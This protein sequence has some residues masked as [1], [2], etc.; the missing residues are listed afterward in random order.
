MVESRSLNVPLTSQ[1]FLFLQ[2]V[3]VPLCT[4][5]SHCT[6]RCSDGSTFSSERELRLRRQW[7]SRLALYG[8]GANEGGGGAVRGGGGGGAVMGVVVVCGHVA[9]RGVVNFII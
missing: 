4:N 2:E 5:A 8:R 9:A 3:L 1:T 6:C 7:I